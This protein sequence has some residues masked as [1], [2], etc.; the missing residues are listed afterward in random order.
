MKRN[1]ELIRALL[2]T[3][4][5]LPDL[6]ATLRPDQLEGYAPEAVTYHMLLLQ[7]AGY[8][9]VT[10]T[11]YVGEGLNCIARRLTWDGQAYLATL[12]EPDEQA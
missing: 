4:E 12:R 10:V 3:V 11:E 7:Q 1:M 2:T 8:L 9:E 6:D 5:A